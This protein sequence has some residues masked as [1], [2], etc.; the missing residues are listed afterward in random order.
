MLKSVPCG[1]NH[2]D[3]HM[4]RTRRQARARTRRSYDVLLCGEEHLCGFVALCETKRTSLATPSTPLFNR[5][6][7][8]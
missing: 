4:R 2:G 3:M 6:N 7:A 5:I 1:I 8:V